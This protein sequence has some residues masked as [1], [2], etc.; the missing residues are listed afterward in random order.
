MLWTGRPS[1]NPTADMISVIIPAYNHEKFV[2]AAISS[3][4][5]Q[6]YGN[7]ELI[8]VDDGS[9]DKT[10]DVIA[11][12][13][14]ARI[15][16]VR[17]ANQD[18]YNALNN[19]LAMARGDCIAILNSDDRYPTDRLETLIEVRER[20]EAACIFTDVRPI[21]AAGAPLPADH[22][23]RAWHARNRRFYF[24]CGDLYTA[25]LRGNL[26]IGTSNLFLRAELARAV[27]GFAPLRYL[28][29]YDYIFRAMLAAPGRVHYLHDRELL[30]YRLH[31]GNTISQGAVIAREQDQR[32]IAKYMQ[33]GLP[34]SGRTRAETGANRLLEL[35]RELQAERYRLAHP[36]RCQIAQMLARLKIE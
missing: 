2:G 16:A 24:Q 8:I 5:N 35:E 25:F 17:Q 32:L 29:D 26:M 7:L 9:S 4:L 31:G 19:G 21:D 12:F 36:W 27:G 18:A 33:A 1:M 34:E 13:R 30:D 22:P 3:V 15:R 23:W 11:G 28:H 6:T 14:D 10:P 20:T